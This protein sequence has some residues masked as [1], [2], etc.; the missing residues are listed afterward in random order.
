MDSSFFERPIL[1]SPYAYPGRHWELD[2][3]GQP[4]G[5]L[6]ESRREAKFI[7]PIPRPKK[8]KRAK[9][10]TRLVFDEGAGVSTAKQQYDPTPIINQLRS[11]VDQW[12]S[13][14]NPTH[15]GVTP[16]TARLLQHWRHHDFGG[17]RPFFC[18]IEAV[19]TVIYLTE[20]APNERAGK[21]FL[22]H[23]ANANNDGRYLRR[24][25]SSGRALAGGEGCRG[26]GSGRDGRLCP[27]CR[28]AAP[29]QAA[30][31]AAGLGM[32]VL[33]EAVRTVRDLVPVG[34]MHLS[35]GLEF[36]AVA[37]MACDDEV[38]P[39]QSRIEA[40]TD[41][42]DLEQVY[43]TERHLL[44]VACTRARDQLLVTGVAPASEFLKD[45]GA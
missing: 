35:K 41:Q 43:D 3:D 8:H 13:I 16:E 15:W 45:L 5:R 7:T 12:R 25:V 31:E 28:G 2:A 38:L 18:Q 21:G 26:S 29:C 40:V 42:G 4:T 37:V 6:I 33:D 14:S 30:V 20:V 11:R 22:D 39:L 27:L 34:T 10:Q 19:E 17:V 24:G 36:R 32:A 1:N 9:G 44:Y 23:L